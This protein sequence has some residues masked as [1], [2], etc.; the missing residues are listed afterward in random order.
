[1]A[2]TALSDLSHD[3]LDSVV[4]RMTLAGVTLPEKQYV[5]FG[6]V[7]VDCEQVVVDYEQS[8]QGLPA[9]QDP[10]PLKCAKLR[11]TQLA[12]YIIR[13]VT[14][15]ADEAAMDAA[16]TIALVDAHTLMTSFIQGYT[17]GDFGGTCDSVSIFS[18]TPVGPSGGF[19]GVC[20][21]VQAQL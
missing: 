13:C 17:A 6:S 20:L 11:T 2:I 4:A 21:R 5:W 8:F 3:I 10:T 19:G 18:I 16:G 15:D 9:A 1:V 14:T 7:A 12:I